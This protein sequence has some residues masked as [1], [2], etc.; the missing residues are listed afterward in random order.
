MMVMISFKKSLLSLVLLLL[1][2]ASFAD[3]HYP[4]ASKHPIAQELFDSGM[5][6]YYA[7][8]YAQAEYNFRQALIHDPNCGLCY[9]GIALAKKQQA[10]EQSQDFA[11]LGFD[12]IKEALSNLSPKDGFLYEVVQATQPSFSQNSTVSSK[13]LQI[14][15]IEALR[16]LHE[17]YKDNKE[18]REESLALLVD[19]MAYYPSVEGDV[20]DDVA[21]NHCSR[22][23][24]NHYKQ[25]AVELLTQAL[26]SNTY[27]DHPG[28][29]HTYIHLA[30]R[31]LNDPLAL[32]A[33]TKLP[34]FSHG[35]IAHYTHMPNHIYWRRGMYDKAIQ[36]NLDA[37]TI[38]Q[39]YFKQNG[40][41]L[42]PYYYEYHYL[43]SHHFLVA[44]GIL[45]N[46]P[47]LSLHYARAIKELMDMN[48]ME[49]TKDYRDTFLSLE[50]VVLARFKKWPEVLKLKESSY[51]ND[52]A[53]LMVNFTHA[54][55]YLNLDKKDQFQALYKKIKNSQYSK[56]NMMDLQTLVIS[57]LQASQMNY[58][59]ASLKQIEDVFLKN[60]VDLIEEK[61]SA[62]N[63]PIWFFP[64]S[65]FLADAAASRQ[66]RSAENTYRVLYQK[67][68]P[69]SHL[70]S[71][72]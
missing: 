62:M 21:T 9:W 57:Y 14:N 1:T 17:R 52:L 49:A 6:N 20:Q 65:L 67:R 47:E 55:A 35:K 16:K 10:L 18:W 54:L 63:P 13:Q 26:K 40:A 69:H 29:L 5:L 45:T 15:Y 23:S 66:D 59:G 64:Y 61:L 42:T 25:E 48:R 71:V 58:Q 72:T 22:M 43:H 2:S 28:L 4:K 68:Y 56:K 27:R 33:A 7:Y 60:K 8:L 51:S 34:N 50:H 53:H 36:A 37:I 44:L 70:K 39:E 19:A 11:E 38:D 41:G 30:E 3:I 24:E 12:N 31:N 46:N 32:I